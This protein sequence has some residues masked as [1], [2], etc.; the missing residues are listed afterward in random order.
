[1]LPAAG[2]GLGANRLCSVP[3]ADR[4]PRSLLDPPAGLDRLD[5]TAVLLSTGMPFGA[6]VSNGSWHTL[7]AGSG[8]RAN[9]TVFD[10]D[11]LLQLALVNPSCEQAQRRKLFQ[12][13][14]L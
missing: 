10:V 3:L 9:W 2:Q 8:S 5:L 1:L 12:C 4:R 11:D 6:H 7:L 14:M 13:L